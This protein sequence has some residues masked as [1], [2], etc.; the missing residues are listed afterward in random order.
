[1]AL[2]MNPDHINDADRQLEA[3]IIESGNGYAADN[4]ESKELNKSRTKR[5]GEIK[6]MGFRTDS[7][8]TAIHVLKDLTP[9][10]GKVFMRDLQTFLRILG[11]KQQDL[12][13][14]EQLR[15]AKR[16]ERAQNKKAAKPR[17]KEELDEATNDNARSDPNAGGAKPAVDNDDA[18]QAEGAAALEAKTPKMSQ[19]QQ[20]AQK[21]AEL[22]LD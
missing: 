2:D 11:A 4:A 19:S 20:A 22:G 9:E 16:V 8:Q 14:D 1:M 18:E 5:R 15:A 3:R 13:P 12:F 17:S 10:E 21:R 7:Y 6:E